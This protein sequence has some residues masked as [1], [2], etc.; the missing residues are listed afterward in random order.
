MSI[1]KASAKESFWRE[2]IARAAKREGSLEAHCRSQNIAVHSLVY[3]RA[4]FRKLEM[5]SKSLV[6]SPFVAVQVKESKV[7]EKFT[8][9][10]DPGWCAEFIRQLFEGAQ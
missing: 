5:K 7:R 4:K 9:L 1:N 6:P 3:W 10:P 2:Q 8:E